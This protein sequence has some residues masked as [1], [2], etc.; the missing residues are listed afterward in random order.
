MLSDPQAV[1]EPWVNRNARCT[2]AGAIGPDP[3]HVVNR[4]KATATETH[5]FLSRHTAARSRK[6]L[7]PRDILGC[8]ISNDQGTRS[9]NCSVRL[10]ADAAL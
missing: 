7:G 9:C 6:G 4:G 5:P 2:P 10:H 8:S 1:G 3:G